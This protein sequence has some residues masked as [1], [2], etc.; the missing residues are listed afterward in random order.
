MLQ[1][2]KLSLSNQPIQLQGF[3]LDPGNIIMGH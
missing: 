3:K 1:D 2:W